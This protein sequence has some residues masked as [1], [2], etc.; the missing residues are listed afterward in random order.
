MKYCDARLARKRKTDR[1]LC[2]YACA[3]AVI[4]RTR[5]ESSETEEAL[6][7]A[8]LTSV[9]AAQDAGVDESDL[10]VLRPTLRALWRK[11]RS[12]KLLGEEKDG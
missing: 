6:A 3:I 10:E 4:V 5:G 1:W 7:A 12:A 9:S 8:G 2:G 11:R